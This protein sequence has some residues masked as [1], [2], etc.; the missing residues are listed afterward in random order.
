LGEYV[1]ENAGKIKDS[2]R[3]YAESQG[4]RLNPDDKVV[5]MIIKGLLA[6][7]EKNGARYCPCRIV[8]GDKEKDVKIICPCAYHRDEIKEMGHCHC[9]L[10]VK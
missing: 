2:Y 8:T 6:N 1:D 7:Q 5:E 10:F 9:N 4:F 3:K